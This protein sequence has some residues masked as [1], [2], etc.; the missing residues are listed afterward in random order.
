MPFATGLEHAFLLDV[1][2]PLGVAVD[3]GGRIY[4]GDESTGAVRVYDERGRLEIGYGIDVR[5]RRRGL[6]SG[7]RRYEVRL[8]ECQSSRF[9]RRRG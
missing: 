7:T 6:T 5:Y 2:R 8:R 4:V 9:A 3:P 1:E